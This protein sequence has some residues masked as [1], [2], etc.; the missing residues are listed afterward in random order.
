MYISTN[1]WFK[2]HTFYF[3]Y[4][5][6]KINKSYNKIMANIIFLFQP[7]HRHKIV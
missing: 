5:K 2:Y 3:Y 7:K 1:F 6:Y 4:N